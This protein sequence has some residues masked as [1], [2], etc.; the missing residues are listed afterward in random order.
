MTVAVVLA[1]AD[2]L[3]GWDQAVIALAVI[4]LCAVVHGIAYTSAEGALRVQRQLLRRGADV[5]AVAGAVA[6]V[7]MLFG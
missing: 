6:I 7:R 3:R 1:F 4:G 2:R 5:V